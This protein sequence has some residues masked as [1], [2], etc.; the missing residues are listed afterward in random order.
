M[1][2]FVSAILAFAMVLLLIPA[3][4][5][6]E[7]GTLTIYKY[8][9]TTAGENGVPAGAYTST[10]AANSAAEAALAQ[11]AIRGVVFSSPRRTAARS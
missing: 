7:S 1:K 8:D 2:K 5:A 6:A 3:A 10:G 9:I 11:Y 4:N